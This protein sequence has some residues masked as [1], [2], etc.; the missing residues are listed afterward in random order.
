MLKTKA[1]K[2][3]KIKSQKN[4]ENEMKILVIKKVLCSKK[5][6][7]T[8]S[9]VETMWRLEKLWNDPD[10]KIALSS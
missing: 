1:V 3:V 9:N 2:K 7:V 8:K 4:N 5:P 6:W 10:R